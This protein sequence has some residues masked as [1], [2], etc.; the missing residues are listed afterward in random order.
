MQV[1]GAASPI[2][3]SGSEDVSK[4]LSYSLTQD[5]VESEAMQ[6]YFELKD[7][8]VKRQLDIKKLRAKLE[9]LSCDFKIYQTSN[10][11]KLQ[12]IQPLTQ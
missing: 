8:N 6:R 5:K 12:N 3:A 2:K 9:N 4:D 11:I 1:S 10:K 7:A